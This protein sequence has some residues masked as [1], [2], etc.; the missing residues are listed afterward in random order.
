MRVKREQVLERNA[1]IA[2]AL[3]DWWEE[4]QAWLKPTFDELE[5]ESEP[6]S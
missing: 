3:P 1:P 2:D 6:E 5:R 4:I